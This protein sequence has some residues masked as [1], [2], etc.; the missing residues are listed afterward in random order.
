MQENSELAV[1][2]GVAL[3][4]DANWD[5]LRKARLTTAHLMHHASPILP[6]ADNFFSPTTSR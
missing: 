4:A 3:R 2:K 1:S 6:I 5:K